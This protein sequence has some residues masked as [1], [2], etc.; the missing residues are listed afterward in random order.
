MRVKSYFAAFEKAVKSRVD[1]EPG[2]PQEI[3]LVDA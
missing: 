3:H 2:E 1:G